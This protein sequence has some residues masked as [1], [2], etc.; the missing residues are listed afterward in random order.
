[1][2]GSLLLLL[3]AFV[4]GGSALLLYEIVAQQVE[5]RHEDVFQCPEPYMNS[6]EHPKIYVCPSNPEDALPFSP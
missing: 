6:H 3:F 5:T 4:W 1:M 2:K